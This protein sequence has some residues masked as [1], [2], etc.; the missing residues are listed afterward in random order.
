M[1][2]LDM[3]IQLFIMAMSSFTCAV[4]G[5]MTL[6]GL[7]LINRA[8]VINVEFTVVNSVL[9]YLHTFIDV[10]LSHAIRSKC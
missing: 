3:D 6:I 4:L 8:F 7:I 5:Q 1:T 9:E 10:K 2:H